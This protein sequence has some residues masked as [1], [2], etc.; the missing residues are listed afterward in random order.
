RAA[1]SAAGGQ[2]RPLHPPEPHERLPRRR[3]GAAAG[4]LRGGARRSGARALMSQVSL[5]D[6]LRRLRRPPDVD[7]DAFTTPSAHPASD[8]P[9]LDRLEETIF[10]GRS[11]ESSL[12]A[13]LE[14]LVAVAPR[15]RQ[16][17]PS[18]EPRAP[19]LAEAVP[20]TR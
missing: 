16:P 18:R 14:R 20:R 5:H 19:P 4:R 10:G 6:K 11:E 8:T 15:G 9:A 13:R 17:E 12:K 1:R 3:G 7:P 2:A